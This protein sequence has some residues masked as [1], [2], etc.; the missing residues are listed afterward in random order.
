METR[1]KTLTALTLCALLLP[2]AGTAGN[3]ERAN[4]RCSL[5]DLLAKLPEE[6][7]SEQEASDLLFS[8]EEEKLARDV[9]ISLYEETELK[10]FRKIKR[11][12]SRHMK[13]VL[14]LLRKY[15]LPDPVAGGVGTFSTEALQTLYEDLVELGR[16]A[17][18]DA[19]TVGA[20][21]EEMDINDLQIQ[22]QR[23]S[24]ADIKTVYQNLL[25][26][27]RNHLRAYVGQLRAR[28]IDYEPDYL[29]PT[30]FQEIVNSPEK[31]I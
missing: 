22:L 10:I 24:N 26:G 6:A 15:D 12:E 16:A 29:D 1:I 5:P 27:S 20:L 21:V 8:R 2:A 19:L 31:A 17:E 4:R 28:G 9:Y 18:E 25:K 7:L 14:W 23:T 11:A 13:A 30:E 3:R